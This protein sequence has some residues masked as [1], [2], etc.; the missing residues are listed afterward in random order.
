M[1]IGDT[2]EELTDDPFSIIPRFIFPVMVDEP[3]EIP[4]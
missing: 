1:V 2:D 4:F 3:V